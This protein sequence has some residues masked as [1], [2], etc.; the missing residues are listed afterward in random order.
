MP[1]PRPSA[2]WCLRGA[3]LALC[4]LRGSAW[5]A[6]AGLPEPPTPRDLPQ[7]WFAFNDDMLGDAILDTDDYRT[8]NANF[9]FSLDEVV[10]AGDYSAF[11]HRL[12]PSY[13]DGTRIDE[14]TLTIGRRLDGWLPAELRRRTLLIAGVGVRCDGD[15]GG[16]SAQ[17]A[18]HRTFGFPQAD[19]T[20]DQR[21]LSTT[22]LAYASAS[23]DS[24]RWPGQG[25]PALVGQL[26]GAALASARGEFQE[27]CGANLALLGEQ[28]SAWIGCDYVWNR[29]R[30]ASAT[31]AVV[32]DHESGTWISAG[33]AK[34]DG[35][36]LSAGVDVRS[37]GVSGS[38][39]YAA[40]SPA[41]AAAAAASA[42]ASAIAAGGKLLSEQDLE[43]FK[44]SGAI[45]LQV[46]GALGRRSGRDALGGA[47]SCE[48][49]FDYHFGT[50][51]DYQWPGNRVDFDQLVIG[52]E[53]EYTLAAGW[54]PRWLPLQLQAFAELGA[55]V[56][57]ERVKV[58]DDAQH[59][60]GQD[61][62]GAMVVQ[63]GAGVR[64]R[65]CDDAGEENPQWYNL[66]WVGYGY[67][68]WHPLAPAPISNGSDHADYLR[69]GMGGHYSVGFTISW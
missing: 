69:P 30:Q 2:A 13:S 34:R 55:G 24:G 52:L 4:C 59:R 9:G 5:A 37:H 29:G 53:P 41:P 12:D 14:L 51:Q 64:L 68:F 48:W 56:R 46:R 28:G 18:I 45:G 16:E 43:Y 1:R 7:L 20:Y 31:A 49:L 44:G 11:T 62:S 61:T 39:G 19:L 35:I 50:D 6:I 58:V 63:P 17:N 8:G 33:L 23:I 47:W 21:H 22:P 54:L 3:A 40:D 66:L 65:W 27:H 67:D 32:A 10:V 57:F 42:P 25:S 15:L 26:E 38:V 60:F 36:F